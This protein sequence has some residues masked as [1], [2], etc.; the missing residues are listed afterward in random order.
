MSSWGCCAAPVGEFESCKTTVPTDATALTVGG[1]VYADIADFVANHPPELGVTAAD[2]GDGTSDL[3]IFGATLTDPKVVSWES[4]SAGPGSAELACVAGLQQFSCEECFAVCAEPLGTEQALIGP[5]FYSA[6][7][8]DPMLPGEFFTPANLI[9]GGSG[10]WGHSGPSGSWAGT[11]LPG[12]KIYVQNASPID[13]SGFYIFNDVGAGGDGI[14]TAV[15]HLFDADGALLGSEPVTIPTSTF[16]GSVP[17]AGSYPAVDHWEIEI[18]TVFTGGGT[19]TDL[20]ITEVGL[21]GDLSPICT[22]FF[23]CVSG[24]CYGDDGQEIAQD[25]VEAIAGVAPTNCANL[26][27]CH[28]LGFV[29]EWVEPGDADCQKFVVSQVWFEGIDRTGDAVVTLNGVAQTEVDQP[30]VGS[31][32]VEVTVDGCTLTETVENAVVEPPAPMWIEPAALAPNTAATSV[33][34]PLTAPGSAPGV[35]STHVSM[36]PTTNPAGAEQVE[37]RTNEL[38]RARRGTRVDPNRIFLDNGL[39]EVPIPIPRTLCRP[40]PDVEFSVDLGDVGALE[41][42]DGYFAEGHWFDAAGA[43]IGTFPITGGDIVNDNPRTVW[44]GTVTPPPGAEG[45]TIAV[46]T[47]SNANNEWVYLY[48][49]ADTTFVNAVTP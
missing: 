3:I 22:E 48:L 26:P 40:E 6:A 43:L 45:V 20:Q 30:P 28:G 12:F 18:L 16:N 23:R 42:G 24:A 4:V 10:W 1:V 35:P 25:D 7:S 49:N 15:I 37:S 19:T 2:N 39:A 38:I 46:E 36:V 44:A 29:G 13:A 33:T 17:F 27:D 31:V 11:Y 47:W 14:E 21:F 5:T 8:S 9:D 34:G 41:A 32:D